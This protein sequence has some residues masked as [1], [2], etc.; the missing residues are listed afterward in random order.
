MAINITPGQL[1]HLEDF[2]TSKHGILYT[3]VT[4]SNQPKAQLGDLVTV[5][6]S[7]FL[8]QGK[9]EVGAQFDSSLS[10]NEPFEFSLGYGQVI[11]G[12]ELTLADMKIG[13]ER[14]VILTPDLAYGNRAISVIP[15][16]ST[17]I[18]YIKLL[19]AA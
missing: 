5:H 15:A 9:N 6:Y 14:I 7:G 4:P 3:I 17:L 10:R 13:E 8:L 19:A 16:N 12:W 18:F 1:L 2:T 11:Q